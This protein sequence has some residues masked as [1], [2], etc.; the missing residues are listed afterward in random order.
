MVKPVPFS[1]CDTH[2]LLKVM[3]EARRELCSAGIGMPRRSLLKAG[4]ETVVENIDELAFL[5]RRTTQHVVHE[6][7]RPAAE[8]P[9]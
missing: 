4:A 7:R 1:L 3:G 9:E 6:A 2:R 8:D 5:L